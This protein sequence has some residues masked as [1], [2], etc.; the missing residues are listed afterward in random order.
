MATTPL[1]FV[2]NWR[3][4]LIAQL[5][6]RSN[7]SIFRTS[8]TAYFVGARGFAPIISQ[9]NLGPVFNVDPIF[10]APYS[11]LDSPSPNSLQ[12]LLSAGQAIS[13]FLGLSKYILFI[14]H[15]ADPWMRFL[16]S[17]TQIT[18]VHFIEEGNKIS[19]SQNDSADSQQALGILSPTIN[20]DSLT[21]MFRQEII[22][23]ELVKRSIFFCTEDNSHVLVR[24]HLF[25]DSEIRVCVEELLT[26]HPFLSK[27]VGIGMRLA[28]I[29]TPLLL[30]A[31]TY[32]KDQL[33]IR[34]I[35]EAFS[36]A[37]QYS[38]TLAYKPHPSCQ[39]H[40]SQPCRDYLLNN[41]VFLCPSRYPIDLAIYVG[42]VPTLIGD[43]SSVLITAKRLGV[44]VQFIG[45]LEQTPNIR[46]DGLM[47]VYQQARSPGFEKEVTPLIRTPGG[48]RT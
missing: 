14:P 19:A 9:L 20:D 22:N 39:S 16:T 13:S 3:T 5:I 8:E 48:F 27:S 36:V 32:L 42:A 34:M 6:V 12:Y 41:A 37:R 38:I 18:A 28:A 35:S 17:I 44:N 24:K 30:G 26:A 46:C 29:D 40:Y 11:Y 43:T 33:F 10:N 23:P 47:H 2:H 45:S 21:C 4:L 1:F 31:K 25:P 15:L 7:Q